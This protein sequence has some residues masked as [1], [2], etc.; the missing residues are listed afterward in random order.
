MIYIVAYRDSSSK[1]FIIKLCMNGKVV[2]T[3]E[4]KPENVNIGGIISHYGKI[5][6]IGINYFNMYPLKKDNVSSVAMNKVKLDDT[7]VRSTCVDNLGNVLLPSDLEVNIICPF[8]QRLHKVRIDISDSIRSVAV[9]QQNN[10]WI[11]TRDG[12]LYIA[13]YLKQFS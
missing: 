2:T 10:L 5:Y 13:K 8:L 9:D 7:I 12:H 6:A 1:Y 11:G 4:A 3:Y